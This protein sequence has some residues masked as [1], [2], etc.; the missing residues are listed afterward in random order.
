MMP[1]HLGNRDLEQLIKDARCARMEF[2]RQNFRFF[3]FGSGLLGLLCAFAITVLVAESTDR[4][5]Q[6]TQISHVAK[7]ISEPPIAA[8]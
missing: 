8:P 2:V 5:Q 4:D 6:A 1:N 7:T 3:A